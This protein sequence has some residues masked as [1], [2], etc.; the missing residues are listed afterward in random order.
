MINW[1][2]DLVLWGFSIVVDLFFREVHPRGSWKV[3]R[4]GP[5]IFVAAPHA[6]QV[7]CGLVS[8][9][10]QVDADS[11]FK[12][13]DPLI[14]MR[15]LRMES[16]RRVAFLIAEKSM[17]RRFVGIFARSAGAV[18]VARALDSTKAAA[19]TIY[20]PNP[21]ND[22]TL[23]RGV[24]T[25]FEKEAEV[26]GLL[27]LPTVNGTA[28]NAEI[29]EIHGPEEVRLKK[30]FKGP[31]ALRQLTGRSDITEQGRFIDGGG[32]G[33]KDIVEGFKGS[34]FKTAPKVDQTKVYDAVFQR[35]EA[36][37]CV[38]IFPEG[39]SH[40]RTELLPLKGKWSTDTIVVHLKHANQTLAGV[41][42][43]ALGSLVAHPDSGLKII[44]CGMNY[45]HAHKFRSRAVVEFGP[46]VEVP[47]ELV[48]L[49]KSGERRE[50]TRQLLEIVY[51]SL[52]AVTVTSPDYDTL[53]VS[54]L[55]AFLA[56]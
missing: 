52:V 43:M 32:S 54:P 51:Q 38:G 26:G 10:L 30:E 47:S 19:G 23:I 35:L 34:T 48:E 36:G 42:I 22:P 20:L 29:V 25:Q 28:A 17:R 8:Q 16:H 31:D 5:V 39:G 7:R 11:P 24:G 9:H 33:E 3:P 55:N 53:M 27:V 45:F 15:V 40:D 1:V 46:P 14:L 13:V 41:A 18:P 4:R 6:N 44:P 49:Y 56:C 2:Y 37:G 50:A 12:F 21:V